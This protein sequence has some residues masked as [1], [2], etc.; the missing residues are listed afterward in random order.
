MNTVE[1]IIIAALLFKAYA[2]GWRLQHLTDGDETY[3]PPPTPAPPPWVGPNPPE[4]LAISMA[5]KAAAF[6]FPTV[7]SIDGELD[8][9]FVPLGLVDNTLRRHM[10][11][12]RVAIL[13]GNGNHGLDIVYDGWPSSLDAPWVAQ[14]M[15]DHEKWVD[16]F[17]PAEVLNLA[18]AELK[19]QRPDR[20]LEILNVAGVSVGLETY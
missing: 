11:T 10:R 4:G 12:G 18:T 8:L 1:R 7:A 15:A 3:L 5:R 19:A 2:A 14:V 6:V 16:T 17:E 9:V 20:L 13:A